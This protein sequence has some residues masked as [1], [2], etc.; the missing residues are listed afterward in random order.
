MTSSDVIKHR[1]Y[2]V[3]GKKANKWKNEYKLLRILLIFPSNVCTKSLFLALRPN[4]YFSHYDQNKEFYFLKCAKCLYERIHFTCF[5]SLSNLLTASQNLSTQFSL[6][7]SPTPFLFLSFLL[8]SIFHN[9]GWVIS[10]VGNILFRSNRCSVYHK[11]YNCNCYIPCFHCH[12]KLEN[13]L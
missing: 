9:H 3:P 2:A 4:L 11:M 1:W 10:V 6:F 5:L 7:S 8:H 13:P 12:A